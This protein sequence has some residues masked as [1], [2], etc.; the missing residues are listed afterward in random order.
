MSQI[1]KQEDY[2]LLFAKAKELYE[3]SRND[4]LEDFPDEI[5]NEFLL[6]GNRA[7][8]E[9]LYFKR[10][11]YLSATAILALFDNRY[12]AELEKIMVAICREKSWM[13][14]AHIIHGDDFVDLFIS[15]TAFVLAE[16]SAVF[17]DKLSD[18]VK[19][20]IKSEIQNQLIEKYIS[21]TFWWEKC[22]MNWA[23]VCGAYVGGTLYYLFPD[24]FNKYKQRIKNTLNCYI[25]GFT[26]DGFCLEG[27]LYWQYGFFSFCVFADLLYK[28]SDG[29]DDL[30]ADK[31]VRNISAYGSHCILKGDS[32]LSFSDADISF[33][34]DYAL[35]HFLHQKLPESVSLPNTDKLCFYDA[36]TKWMNYYRA[37]IWHNSASEV[38]ESECNEIY[39]PK[40][41]QL[42]I[43]QKA[44]SFAIK[45]GHNNEPHN[46]NDLGSFIYA[47]KDGQ[48]F[49]DLGAGRYTKDYF[50]NSKR[51]NIFCNSSLSH[52][53]AIIDSK[54]QLFGENY[55][56]PLLYKNS[57]AVCDLTEA[58]SCDALISYERKVQINSSGISLTD[59]F[60]LNDNIPITERFVSKRKAVENKCELIF[61]NTKLK[62]SKEDVTLIISEH[63]HTP[64]EYDS[65]DITVY[66]YDFI[67]K[68]TTREISFEITTE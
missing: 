42:I 68:E 39:S 19:D 5:R 8:F 53:T 15:E 17:G 28:Q 6:N 10:R 34:P 51:Y 45:G 54:A 44:Y 21:Q 61:G 43:N 32:A 49:C 12:I 7:E 16:I 48:V 22:D 55:S 57:V 36:N 66:S 65:E 26:D 27:P 41:N 24:K 62:Y 33:R 60:K 1:Y 29:K 38:S 4:N 50:D 14:P 31:K 58:Y 40:A 3:K 11:D 9:K 30:F 59:S 64:H 67:L 35:M 23:A 46:H 18:K 47:D 52:N 13:L 63:K 56:A 20:K 25:K 2:P 37:L